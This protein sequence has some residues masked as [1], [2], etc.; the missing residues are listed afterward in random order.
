MRYGGRHM[1]TDAKRLAQSREGNFLIELALVL[2]LLLATL[3]GAYDYG[4]ALYDNM[5][6]KEAVRAG[7]QYATKNPAYTPG[8]L[9]VVA[10]ASGIDPS[11][12]T[13]SA[14]T[15]YKCPDGTSASAGASC[16]GGIVEEYTTVNAQ[17]V[18]VPLLTV[19]GSILPSTLQAAATLRVH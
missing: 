13:L 3:A 10:S 4:S 14:T 12:L 7:A 16:A 8:I 2:P 6:L 9:Q 11:R 15:S 5:A 18:V 17:A 1:W 19:F